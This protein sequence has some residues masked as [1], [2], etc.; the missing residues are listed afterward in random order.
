ME[1][2]DIGTEDVTE[3][4]EAPESS[5]ETPEQVEEPAEQLESPEPET[6]EEP[7][8]EP[9]E[10]PV[11]AEEPTEAPQPSQEPK[12]SRAQERIRDLARENREL[13]ERMEAFTRQTAPELQNEEIGYNDLNKVINERAMQAAELLMRSNQVETEFKGQALKWADDFDQVKRE[14]PALDPES[15]EYDPEFD[16][17]LARL[18]DDGTGTPRVDVLVS[19]VIKTFKK[20]ESSISSKAKEAGKSE[21]T[22]KLAKQM[23]ESAITPTAKAPS[24]AEKYT[25]EELSE[26]RMNDPKRYMKLIDELD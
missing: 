14:N 20:R 11:E 19:D 25:D 7:A 3:P 17:T 9:T 1:L 4:A 21:V 22:A 15:P 2:R 8:Q 26:I 5:P 18:I 16:A 12:K 13:K 24:S 23:G 6:A 10:P